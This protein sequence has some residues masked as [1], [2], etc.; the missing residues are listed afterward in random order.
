MNDIFHDKHN[1]VIDANQMKVESTMNF[2]SIELTE[3]ELNLISLIPNDIL[4]L[5]RST[6][7]SYSSINGFDRIKDKLAFKA[8]AELLKLRTIHAKMIKQGY[9]NYEDQDSGNR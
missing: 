5:I 9:D 4:V 7:Q 3:E 1:S 6:L 2:D 8:L